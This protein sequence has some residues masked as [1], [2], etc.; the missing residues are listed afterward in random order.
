MSS[1]DVL[2]GVLSLM[3]VGMFCGVALMGV[4]LDSTR[5][6][7]AAGSRQYVMRQSGGFAVGFLGLAGM[8]VGLGLNISI[9]M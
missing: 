6:D 4:R 9:G 7:F 5:L 3:I 2:V 8:L 1:S